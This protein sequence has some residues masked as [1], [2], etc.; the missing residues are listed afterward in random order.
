MEDV[1]NAA[2]QVLGAIRAS[3]QRSGHPQPFSVFLL[4]PETR[5]PT[6]LATGAA[7]ARLQTPPIGEQE[8]YTCMI[9]YEGPPS[10]WLEQ[11]LGKHGRPDWD[12]VRYFHTG[13]DIGE[14]IN[15][16]LDAFDEQKAKP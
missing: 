10:R 3:R 15:A 6:E 13:Q 4:W 16:A 1:F 9:D 8:L 11:N 12:A 5:D 14:L 2:F 7:Q